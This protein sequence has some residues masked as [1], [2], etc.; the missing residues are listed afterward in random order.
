MQAWTWPCVCALPFPFGLHPCLM[1]MFQFALRAKPIVASLIM[2][3]PLP[4]WTFCLFVFVISVFVCVSICGR[5]PALASHSQPCSQSVACRITNSEGC[6]RSHQHNLVQRCP[7]GCILRSPR[8]GSSM[9]VFRGAL[10]GCFIF[11]FSSGF[12]SFKEAYDFR[13]RFAFDH[14]LGF[15][16]EGPVNSQLWSIA[17]INIGSLKTSTA[18]RTCEANVTC[19]QET[20]IGTYGLHHASKTV[21]QH[22]TCLFHGRPLPGLLSTHGVTRTPHGGVAILAARELATEFR[23]QEDATGLYDQLFATRRVT[24]CWV[25]VQPT[26][27]LLAFSFYGKTGAS[28][29]KAILEFNDNILRDIFTVASQFGDVPVVIAGDFQVAPEH[30]TS[31]THAVHFHQW[32]DVLQFADEDGGFR[33]LTFSSNGCFTGPGDGCSSIDG[34]ITNS[35]ASAALT[36]AEVLP[37]LRVQHRPVRASFNWKVVWQR[38]FT[39]FKPAPFAFPPSFSSDSTCEDVSSL[40]HLS[41]VNQIWQEANQQCVDALTRAGAT[42]GPGPQHRGVLVQTRP[43]N[44]C[45]GQC[46]S[47]IATTS[48]SS[49]LINALK[50]LLE[51]QAFHSQEFRQGSDMSLLG[52]P[53]LRHGLGCS[54]CVHHACGHAIRG[55]LWS[56]LSPQSNGRKM[57]LPPMKSNLSF[58]ASSVG[59][60]NFKTRLAL[61]P[62]LSIGI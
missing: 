53:S 56:K 29:D 26:L 35:V 54:S 15:P 20:R 55:P 39:L 32:C 6:S 9:S 23:P 41:D 51:I 24:A 36:N 5:G 2:C 37:Y 33:P 47:G 27:K 43:K 7:Q 16:G 8:F 28:A 19:L 50:G 3:Y 45:P 42:W 30:Y 1:L 48:R 14:T 34:I 38:G 46:R 31:V 52:E 59:K 17:T 62:L 49:W 18:W 58:D 61:G 40:H 60:T 10:L 13:L 57:H 12:L 44:V 22:G 21:E 11:W 25:Q 4:Q